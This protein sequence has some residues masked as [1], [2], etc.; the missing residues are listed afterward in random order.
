MIRE[1]DEHLVARP[2][3][4]PD[5]ALRM[6]HAI[7]RAW[8]RDGLPVDAMVVRVIENAAYLN[9]TVTTDLQWRLADR[10][11]RLVP[12]ICRVDNGL[13]VGRAQSLPEN[14]PGS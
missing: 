4:P 10:L 3:E 13:A 2:G 12:G 7:R 8:R 14:S 11:A 9:G 1:P 5:E 6:A